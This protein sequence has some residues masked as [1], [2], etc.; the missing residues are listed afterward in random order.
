MAD[1]N[2]PRAPYGCPDEP[3]RNGLAF[4]LNL[5]ERQDGAPGGR[6]TEARCRP[7]RGED[8][9]V[10]Q[11]RDRGTYVIATRQYAVVL[12]ASVGA[13]QSLDDQRVGVPRLHGQ[14]KGRGLELGRRVESGW[15]VI[16]V[17]NGNW[18]K[19]VDQQA[20]GEDSGHQSTCRRNHQGTNRVV[21]MD[22]QQFP[23]RASNG[24]NLLR[25]GNPKF[26]SQLGRNRLASKAAEHQFRTLKRPKS[27]QALSAGLQ[28]CL[29]RG[30]L[31]AGGLAIKVRRHDPLRFQALHGMTSAFWLSIPRLP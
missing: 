11:A 27:M 31:V 10:L 19:D 12:N 18:H 24:C 25:Y 4:Y 7:K 1:A 23:S 22:A 28:M 16:E 26:Q 5:G 3:S 29:H 2:Q 20:E 15:N 21:P 6:T 8:Q 14:F 9:H 13:Y 17:R 30:H